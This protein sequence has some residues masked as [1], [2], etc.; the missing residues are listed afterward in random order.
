M[1]RPASVSGPTLLTLFPT[2]GFLASVITL[3]VLDESTRT[4]PSLLIQPCNCA[5]RRS[6]LSLRLR[7]MTAA[8]PVDLA[9]SEVPSMTREPPFR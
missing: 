4:L 7:T 9:P 5:L 8:P 2:E 3:Q 1:M 6:R